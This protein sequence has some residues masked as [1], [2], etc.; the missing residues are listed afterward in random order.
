MRLADCEPALLAAKAGLRYVADSE[1]G[2]QR[3]RWGRGF[4]YRDMEGKTVREQALRQ[5]FAALVIPP[6]WQEVWICADEKGHIQAT[7]RDDAGRKQ[8]IYHP[9]W[10]AVRDYIKFERLVLFAEALPNL[11]AR[12]AVD[13]RK[14]KLTQ[15]KVTALVVRLLEETLIRI[16]NSQYAKQN[17]SYGLTTLQDDHA[18]IEKSGVLFEFRGKSGKEHEVALRDRRL[19]RL[20]KACQDLPGQHLFQYLDEDGEVCALESGAVNEY[21]R[22]VTACEFTAKD[23]RTWGGTIKT[24]HLLHQAGAL[25]SDK[26]IEQAITTA[27]K[28]TAE[29]LGNTP[30]IC[31]D[32]Y[33]HPA[34]LDRYRDQTL[35]A[36]YGRI[37]TNHQAEK[38]GLTLDEAVVLEIIRNANHDLQ[39][40]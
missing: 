39:A 9:R 31:R 34:V 14:R 15:A 40:Q 37:A 8:Y 20:V 2:Y 3:Q 26:A 30:S 11:R 12:V 1:E 21:L 19:A 36:L 38:H 23:F 16:G 18:V 28:G 35:L 4:T 32:H 10:G 7:G 13:L 33:I 24:A 22:T 25:D 27:I 5:R 29:E 6:A 17:D